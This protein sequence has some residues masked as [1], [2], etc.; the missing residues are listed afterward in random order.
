MGLPNRPSN[1]PNR[2]SNSANRLS[3]LASRP[4]SLA[5]CPS[6]LAN[7]PSDL[8]NC[9]SNLANCLSNLA[10]RLLNLANRLL[11][12]A[13]RLLNLA[14]RLLNLAIRLLNLAIRLLNLANR[15]FNLANRLSNLANRLFNLTNR[16]LL[17]AYRPSL[18]RSSTR[19]HRKDRLG[20]VHA[21]LRQPQT[22]LL[23]LLRPDQVPDDLTER[24]YRLHKVELRAENSSSTGSLVMRH[25]VTPAHDDG[26]ARHLRDTGAVDDPLDLQKHRPRPVDPAEQ[27]LFVIAQPAKPVL[28]PSSSRRM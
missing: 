27:H 7:C 13:N 5:N 18:S 26:V 20:N 8:A 25:R 3:N 4:S 2:P 1:L 10:N 15:P 24:S 21:V 22:L 9:L 6:N 12:L 14:N 19:L 16:L 23:R 11:N 28:R 17:F